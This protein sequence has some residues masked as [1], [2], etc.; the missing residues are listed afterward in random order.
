MST[1]RKRR[2]NKANCRRLRERQREKTHWCWPS[3]PFFF[4]FL[5]SF[6]LKKK[7]KEIRQ[8]K[9]I[10]FLES[11]LVTYTNPRPITRSSLIIFYYFL[12][13]SSFSRY[14]AIYFDIIYSL[15]V[16]PLSLGS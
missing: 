8:L 13:F 1:T 16:F 9:K 12:K 3:S 15:T 7:K 11:N 2:D 14:L 5:L 10:V 6:T 4:P